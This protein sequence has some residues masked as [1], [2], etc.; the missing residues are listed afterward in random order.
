MRVRLLLTSVVALI[1]LS[2][3]TVGALPAASDSPSAPAP[4]PGALAAVSRSK[5]GAD[6]SAALDACSLTDT[7]GRFGTN[8]PLGIGLAVA[9]GLVPHAADV[10]K[11]APFDGTEPELQSDSPAWVI[12]TKGVVSLPLAPDMIDPTCV[13]VNGVATWFS[14]GSIEQPDGSMKTARPPKNAPIYGLPSLTP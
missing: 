4:A 14:T 9:M 3:C 1:G 11:Y 5:P 8:G 6:A 10:P 2:G 7:T 12:R 13:V